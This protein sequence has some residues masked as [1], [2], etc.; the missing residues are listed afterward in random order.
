MNMKQSPRL[1]IELKTAE[2]VKL[3]DRVRSLTIG[4]KDN[5]R[6]I[7]LKALSEFCTNK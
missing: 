6:T 4:T 2:E 5:L 1:V 7:V 3:R